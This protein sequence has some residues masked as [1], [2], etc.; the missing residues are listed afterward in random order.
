[1]AQSDLNQIK[2]TLR[3]TASSDRID[4]IDV[5]RG[6]VVF[7]ILIINVWGFGLPFDTTV[8]PQLLRQFDR[9]DEFTFLATWIGFEG[10]QR[11]IFS[12]LFGAGVILLT[13]R[14]ESDDRA[15]S[16]RSIYYRRTIC[17]ILF[18][19]IDAY[20][21]LWYGDILF[22]YGVLGLF[23]YFLRNTRPLKLVIASG[24]VICLV[25]LLN[26]GLGYAVDEAAP[27][28]ESAQQKLSLGEELTDVERSALEFA[29]LRPGVTSP[30]KVAQKVETRSGG[31]FSAFLPNAKSSF[32][33]H[34]VFGLIS[35]FWDA[36]AMMM[37]GMALYKWHVFDA[38]R[39][40]RFYVCMTVVGLGIGLSVNTWEMLDSMSHNY[41]DTFSYW[42][43]DIGRLAMA[44]GYIGI[45]MLVCKMGLLPRVRNAFAAIGR[46]A[47]TN[48]LV[49]SVIC[50]TFF[51]VF[52]F[53]GQLQFHQLYYVV[54]AIWILQLLYSP[55][56]LNRFRYG[57]VEWV[58]RSITYR[59]LL[60]IKKT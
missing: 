40:V 6:L 8:N 45:I 5:L 30:E 27:H 51:V 59:Q 18:G 37:L 57:P 29:E 43:Y 23:L 9:L 20:L 25:A 34:I 13:Q 41:R 52:G 48:Y 21:L 16:A 39:G 11:A 49:H 3:P 19:L 53:F 56:W 55:L 47:L 46:M 15:T 22:T 33:F 54:L 58:W 24:V 17:L 7:G 42:S 14:I 26:F 4:S 10:S 1:M 35:L 32:E 28:I 12:M 44:F 2:P 36:L 50:T 60:T 31:Y 38:S